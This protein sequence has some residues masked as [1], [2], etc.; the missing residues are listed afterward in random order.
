MNDNH[1]IKNHSG[2]IKRVA[3]IAILIGALMFMFLMIVIEAVF[4]FFPTMR[5]EKKDA[6]AEIEY[7]T[8]LIEHNYLTGLSDKVKEI[9]YNT[10]EEIRKDQY[11]ANYRDLYISL[12]NE[13][14]LDARYY[15]YKCRE[16]TW[17][18]NVVLAFYDEEYR[19]LV[20]IVDGN[21]NDEAL[22][23]GQWLSTDAGEVDDIY[24]IRKTAASDWYMPIGYGKVS[25]WNSTNY[26]P[27][28]DDNNEVMGYA[29]VN[30]PL[31]ALFTQVLV[32]LQIYV[33]TMLV[34]LAIY[35]YFGFKY[36]DNRLLNNINK[37]SGAAAKY[38]NVDNV[39]IE[40]STSY[41]KDLNIYTEDEFQDLWETMV[42]M[43]N[44]ISLA[45]KQVKE[46]AS[47]EARIST[48]LEVAKKIQMDALP[49]VF[50]AFPDRTDFD[51]YANMM[52]AK[53]IS[54]DFYDFFMIDDYHLGLAIADVS[55]KG[56]PAALFM[57]ISK[58]LLR[59]RTMGG[60]KP[61]EILASLN[62]RLCEGN[63]E[64][65]FVTVWLGILD[66]RTGEVIAAN[67]GHE[68]P[69]IT[70]EAGQFRLFKDPHGLMC[71]AFENMSYVDYTI[72]IPKG[73]KLFVYTDGVAEAQDKDEELFGLDRL[74]ESLNKYSDATPREVIEGIHGEIAAFEKGT[75]RFDD[76]TML[77]VCY[78]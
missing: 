22:L 70:D 72:Q 11:S 3:A 39:K 1:E 20:C 21:T 52:P 62:D 13:D 6:A 24:T 47:K 44:D 71:G 78:K 66:T 57:M 48:E 7:V 33:P 9:Y 58:K 76:I 34:I 26:I 29:C 51:I 15:L 63:T 8:V 77:C 35:I 38:S 32:F 31:N 12:L 18:H 37:L 19:R 10:P 67:A 54:G 23:P 64:T 50:P 2:S 55:G 14:Y 30:I 42:N 56:V 53:E 65:M 60:G 75:E 36:L 40:E 73:G 27:I 68:F 46:S 49:S 61:S 45:M 43:E 69:F 16:Y 41:F 17:I 5:D 4:L 28:Y 25:G 74:E 59:I